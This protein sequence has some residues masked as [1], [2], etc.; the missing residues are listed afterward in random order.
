MILYHLDR[1]AS[2]HEGQVLTLQSLNSCNLE[3]SEIVR[4]LFP[5]GLSSH[6]IQYLKKAENTFDYG[7][8][9]PSGNYFAWLE[10]LR[11]ATD[12]LGGPFSE[13]YCELIRRIFFPSLPS[14]LQC[15]FAVSDINEFSQW[16]DCIGFSADKPVFEVHVPDESPCFDSQL[17]KAGFCLWVNEIEG[18]GHFDF[19]PLKNLQFAFDYWN[20]KRDSNSRLEYLIPL[21]VTVGRQV[22]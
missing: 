22:R 8:I 13:I 9:Q 12:S 6:G 18:K 11:S 21:P 5:D 17:L 19:E 4:N 1:N 15:L 2:L 16:N 14:R 10:S 3:N 7:I 20:G